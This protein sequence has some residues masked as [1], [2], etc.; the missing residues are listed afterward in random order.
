MIYLFKP[1]K[2]ILRPKQKQISL[3]RQRR[4]KKKSK[5]GNGNSPES[6]QEGLVKKIQRLEVL[7]ANME[8]NEILT[9]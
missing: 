6:E 7:R 8:R 2:S 4:L 1:F 9:Q 5:K 3:L